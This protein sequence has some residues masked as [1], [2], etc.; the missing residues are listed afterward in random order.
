MGSKI[1]N[2]STQGLFDTLAK[3]LLRCWIFGF[4]LLLIWFGFYVLLGDVIH[5]LHGNM[6]GLSKNELNVIHYCGMGLLKLLVFVFFLF[7]WLA[8]KMVLSKG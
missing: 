4:V 5:G 3:V 8:I 2:D 1:M 6:F 7:P